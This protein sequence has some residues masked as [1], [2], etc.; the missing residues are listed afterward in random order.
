MPSQEWHKK[1]SKELF[2]EEFEKLTQIGW[3]TPQNNKA[4]NTENSETIEIK[5]GNNRT[6]KSISDNDI[7]DI[8]NFLNNF[9]GDFKKIFIEDP[10]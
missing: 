3:T 1:R 5:E 10:K 9:D 7:L 4:P 2:G 6:H 8:K